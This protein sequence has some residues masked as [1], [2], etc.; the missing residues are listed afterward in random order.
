MKGAGHAA[1]IAIAWLLLAPLA[2]A[3]ETHFTVESAAGGVA[4]EVSDDGATWRLRLEH[5][6]DL[7]TTTQALGELLAQAFARNAP[8]DGPLSIDVGRIIEH[9]WLSQRLAEA[10]LHSPRWDADLGKP[11]AASDNF[12]VA[13]ILD[14][15]RL[16]EAWAFVF[17]RHGLRVRSAS[18]E[19]VLVGSV[20]KTAALEPLAA[21]PGAAGKRLPFDAILWLQLER[22]NP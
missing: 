5:P 7:E 22:T 19:K 6:T 17:S 4:L 16:V 18:V 12:A 10:A 14:E 21:L 8:P 3:A 20:G 11:R 15:Q 9:P 13:R 2:A 1:R